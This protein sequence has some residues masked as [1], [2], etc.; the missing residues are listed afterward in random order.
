MLVVNYDPIS[1]VYLG[2]RSSFSK[3]TISFSVLSNSP[4]V[5]LIGRVCH[6]IDTERIR[7]DKYVRSNAPKLDNV[8][9]EK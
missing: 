8:S 5:A 9:G 4:P 2:L 7:T 6:D 3:D 1:L